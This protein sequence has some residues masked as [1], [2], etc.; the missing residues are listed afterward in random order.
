MRFKQPTLYSVVYVMCKNKY[1]YLMLKYFLSFFALRAF[2]S[3]LKPFFML[4]FTHSSSKG[5]KNADFTF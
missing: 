5:R 2:F 1:L 4:F 3:H